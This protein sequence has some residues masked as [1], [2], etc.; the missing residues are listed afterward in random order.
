MVLT[1]EVQ[2][3]LPRD[4]GGIV[5]ACERRVGEVFIVRDDSAEVTK[6]IM[7]TIQDYLDIVP[8][9]SSRSPSRTTPR[10]T[11]GGSKDV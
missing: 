9:C 2:G 1:K 8:V 4:V 10:D 7:V 3:S 6:L 11:E 5:V